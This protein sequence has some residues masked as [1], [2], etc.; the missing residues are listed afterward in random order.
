VNAGRQTRTANTAPVAAASWEVLQS[1][2]VHRLLSTAQIREIHFADASTRWTQAVMAG[3]RTQGLVASVRARP[4][5]IVSL[6][7]LTERGAKPVESS[8]PDLPR[9]RRV[10]LSPEGARGPLQAHTLAVNDVGIAFLREA[11]LHDEDFGP[12]D[13]VHEVAH[14]LVASSGRARELLIPDALVTY[15]FLSSGGPTTIQRFLELDRAT[16][17]CHA[18]V[19]K[20][21]TYVRFGEAETY[22]GHGATRRSDGKLHRRWYQSMPDVMVVMT[23]KERR[24]LDTRLATV[25]G[26]AD[27][28]PALR[29]ARQPHF[30]FTTL[31]LLQERGPFAPI[32]V[33]A[34]RPEGGVDCLGHAAK[35]ESTDPLSSS[36][37]DHEEEGDGDLPTAD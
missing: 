4:P 30:Y 31:D 23:G 3:L 21:L 13:W 16:T 32:C 34:D 22:T 5:R 26:L 8:C 27:A 29:A 36:Q 11:R 33:R 37:L 24:R 17:A 2:Y 7:F 15:G 18:L 10:L 12:L 28:E 1:L 14:P 20:M 25:I 19:A 9:A 35:G 6:F